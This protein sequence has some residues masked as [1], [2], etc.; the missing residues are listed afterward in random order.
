MSDVCAR[1]EKTS[2]CSSKSKRRRRRRNFVSPLSD[3]HFIGVLV[4]RRRK[5][6]RHYQYHY[7]IITYINTNISN[8]V[9]TYAR[10]SSQ[11]FTLL[12]FRRRAARLTCW[13]R[14][15]EPVGTYT[16]LFVVREHGHHARTH[17]A[18]LPLTGDLHA[19][20]TVRVRPCHPTQVSHENLERSA[21]AVTGP[22]ICECRRQCK[23]P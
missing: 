1:S 14:A 9:Y 12:L 2:M 13:K 20:N 11:K 6:N 16:N 10:S 7:H 8:F 18:R 15:S 23:C 3:G 19:G 22:E 21:S 4:E 5:Q 17:L